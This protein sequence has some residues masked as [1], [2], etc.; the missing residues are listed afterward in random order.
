MS[1]FLIYWT[2]S[3]SESKKMA[4]EANSDEK[5][6]ISEILNKNKNK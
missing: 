2:L 3:P 5:S 1:L 6:D 4:M